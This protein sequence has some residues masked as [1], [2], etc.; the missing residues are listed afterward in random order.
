MK[1]EHRATPEK[2]KFCNSKDCFPSPRPAFLLIAEF[3]D[4]NFQRFNAPASMYT[5]SYDYT[6]VGWHTRC[7]KCFY[8]DPIRIDK[9]YSGG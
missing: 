1:S 9:T 3:E 6:I 8:D 4:I 2:P 7:V 5:N